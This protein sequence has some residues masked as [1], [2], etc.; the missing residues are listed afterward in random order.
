L[1]LLVVELDRDLAS[2]PVVEVVGVVVRGGGAQDGVAA[3]V[4]GHGAAPLRVGIV[5]GAVG[6]A[7]L[8]GVTGV[9]TAWRHLKHASALWT[10]AYGYAFDAKMLCVLIVA[11][12]GAWNWRRMRPRLTSDGAVAALQLSAARELVFAGVVL[13]ITAMLVSLPAPR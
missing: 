5:G 12:L 3:D 8:L 10:T 7:A 1:R 13:V 11:G 9:V 4:D 2:F 6:A